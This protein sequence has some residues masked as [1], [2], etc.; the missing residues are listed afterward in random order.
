MVVIIGREGINGLVAKG[1][2]PKE[3]ANNII[4]HLDHGTMIANGK[5]C[6]RHERRP[7]ALYLIPP[8]LPFGSPSVP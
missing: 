8:Q 4:I 5:T 3:F 1:A 6:A 7:V 2:H